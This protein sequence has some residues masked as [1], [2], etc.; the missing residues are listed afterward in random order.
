MRRRAGHGAHAPCSGRFNVAN[1]LAAAATALD[2]RDS[3]S[4][5]V[6]AGLERAGRRCP[7]GWSASTPARTSRSSS[8]TRT[9]PTRSGRARRGARAR[10][11]GGRLVV[12]FGCGGDRDRAKRPLMGEVAARLRRPRYPSPPTIRAPRT[13]HA[14]AARRA[15]RHAAASTRCRRSS[16]TGA[17]A[18][19]DALASATGGDVVVIAGKGHETG[20]TAAGRTD[21]VRR[22]RRRARG[23]G[24]VT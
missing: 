2:R 21:P 13:R 23:A 10:R 16:S 12:V 9:R 19:R 7:G 1:A 22:P 24:G 20:Q 8:T 15:R 6:V 11:T 18:I 4:A 17:P 5:T 3:T 14:I